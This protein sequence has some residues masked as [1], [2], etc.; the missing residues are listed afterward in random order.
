MPALRRIADRKCVRRGRTQIVRDLIFIGLLVGSPQVAIVAAQTERADF[1]A[2]QRLLQRLL[3]RSAD[4]HRFA[5]ALHLRHQRRIGFGELFERETRDLGDDVIDRRFETGF[6]LLR[7][8]VGQF[9]Q[10]ITDRQ[11]GSDLGDRESRSPC[12]PARCCAKRAGSSRS[13]SSARCRV[14]R[15][16]N[17]RSAGFDA[18]LAN[19]GQ[20][21]VAHPL[22]FFVGQRLRRGDGDRV[23]GVH[24]HRDQSFRCCR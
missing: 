24:A 10:A 20:R 16:L 13:R 1:Q 8:V 7:D 18:D 2:A 9:P 6:G 22:V 12:W 17:V 15:E 19:H 11:L 21:S 14:N 23:A 4:R 3:E 5:D